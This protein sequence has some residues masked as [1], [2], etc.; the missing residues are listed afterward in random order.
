MEAFDSFDEF[1]TKE[2]EKKVLAAPKAG[3]IKA[4]KPKRGRKAKVVDMDV[5]EVKE[6][7]E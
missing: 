2:V 7:E 1:E 3:M 4:E 6:V 5:E